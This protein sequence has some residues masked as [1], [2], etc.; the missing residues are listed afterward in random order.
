MFKF[1]EL[2]E[3]V[4]FQDAVKM[5]AQKFG[6]ALPETSEGAGDDDGVAMR[7]CARRC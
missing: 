7:R 1:L 5:L 4:G 3:K 6:L 2:H